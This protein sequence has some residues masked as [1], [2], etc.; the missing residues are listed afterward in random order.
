MVQPRGN[1]GSSYGEVIRRA[2]F[3]FKLS[4]GNAK[5]LQVIKPKALSGLGVMPIT[6]QVLAHTLAQLYRG[7]DYSLA[8]LIVLP[9][10]EL[11]APDLSNA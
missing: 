3:P 8:E 1:S 2:L 4:P 7:K 9:C 11:V 5:G 10:L 6:G